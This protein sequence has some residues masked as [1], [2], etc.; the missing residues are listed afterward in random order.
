M[1]LL[2][3]L[4]VLLSPPFQE[5]SLEEL[6]RR[7]GS[8]DIEVR[9][10]A[11]AEL[12][13]R[14]PAV[15]PALEEAA[16]KAGAEGAAPLRPIIRR[17]RAHRWTRVV[18][19]LDNPFSP[20]SG[21]LHLLAAPD[22][23][24]AAGSDARTVTVWTYPEARYVRPWRPHDD[25]VSTIHLSHDGSRLLT[26]GRRDRELA[27]WEFPSGRAIRKFESTG[28]SPRQ[29]LATPD[30]AHLAVACG[31]VEWIE[32]AT[33]RVVWKWTP[34]AGIAH[35]LDLSPDGKSLLV[36][37]LNSNRLSIV[38]E[39]GE[40]V[41]DVNVRGSPGY[42]TSLHWIS[43][44]K[45]AVVLHRM[46]GGRKIDLSTGQETEQVDPT[47]MFTLL[48]RTTR[49]RLSRPKSEPPPAGVADL[50]MPGD[51]V[52]NVFHTPDDRYVL[53]STLNGKTVRCFDLR[54]ANR[55]TEIGA[56][57]RTF[58]WGSA[59]VL[60][61]TRAGEVVLYDIQGKELKRVRHGEQEVRMV[62]FAG[63]SRVISVGADHA[64][65]CFDLQTG[66]ALWSQYQLPFKKS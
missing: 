62:A 16:R 63:G 52:T 4:L 13:G 25:N 46:M 5:P 55:L 26:V 31:D 39:A 36:G 33:G 66:K 60:V 28:M 38:N 45:E 10:K 32:A 27:L 7:L 59:G 2:P 1:R 48:G 17:L 24:T 40:L 15:L 9:G 11:A 53:A 54:Q 14:G 23:K 8:D 35:A 49:F 21:S 37:A 57:V 18:A 3:V 65:R 19:S 41:R 34:R 12:V 44:G 30:G 56:D 20:F 58:A 50:E 29:I 51:T 43:D 64:I 22:G 47:G 42:E 61:G 6:L